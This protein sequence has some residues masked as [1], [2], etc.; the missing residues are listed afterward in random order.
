MEMLGIAT[1]KNKTAKIERNLNGG[2]Q[3]IMGTS[4]N[5][6]ANARAQCT[7]KNM[8]LSDQTIFDAHG[9]GAILQSDVT[10]DL[11]APL[12]RRGHMG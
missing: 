11:A 5:P 6:A 9:L 2:D 7:G 4:N 12:I 10:A 8:S 1:H 3:Q